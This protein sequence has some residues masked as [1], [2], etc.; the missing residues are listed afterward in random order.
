MN[1]KLRSTFLFLVFV[2][3]YLVVIA[4]LFVIQIWQRDF[5]VNLGRKQYSVELISYPVRGQI[6]DRYGQPVALNKESISAF[7]LP[8]QIQNRVALVKFLNKYAPSAVG[9]LDRS[10]KKYFMYV[11]RR[12]SADFYNCA[13]SADLED[14]KFMKEPS[15]FYPSDAMG[16]IIGIT[17]IDNIGLFGLEQQYNNYLSGQLSKVLLE[18]EARSA[19]FYFKRELQKSGLLGKD[20]RLTID[21]DLQYLVTEALSDSVTKLE[22]ELGAV[23]VLDPKS[24]DILAMAGCPGFEPNAQGE[25]DMNRVKPIA[26]CDTY[27]LG[28]VMKIFVALAAVSEGVVTA[29]E[30]IDCENREATSIDGMHFTTVHANG[31][32]PFS[33]VIVYS[34]NIGMVKVAK[35]LNEK[36]YDHYRKLGFGIKT[37]LNF[38]GEQSGYVSHPK[39]WSKRSIISLSFGYEI[40]ANLLQ[41]ARA[42][43]VIAND[44]VLVQPRLILDQPSCPPERIYS[45]EPVRIIQNMLRD[46]VQHGTGVHAKIKGYDVIGKTGTARLV[47]NGGYSHTNQIYTFAGIVQK[48]NYSRVIITFIK[49]TK[50]Y[51]TL[52]GAN[53]AAPLFERVAE[54]ALIR[55]KVTCGTV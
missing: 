12:C 16:Q 21:S 28:S 5:F 10:A 13:Q 15:R 20:L 29:D 25:L 33:E 54:L 34:N 44:G 14:L 35:R 27:E 1:S 38:A 26:L 8:R 40:T 23:I 37:G 50:N 31:K 51:R 43:G 24:G 49:N 42:F 3:L 45:S 53:T 55:D 41:L 9:R 32:I 52:Y 7:I 18:K 6:L 30:I 47:V 22:A 2:G 36:L 4:N 17:D 48:G 11:G 39:R 46:T 19:K